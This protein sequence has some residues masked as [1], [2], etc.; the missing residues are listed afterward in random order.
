MAKKTSNYNYKRKIKNRFEREK[1][2]KYHHNSAS[3]RK[4]PSK[5]TQTDLAR[6]LQ[7]FLFFLFSWKRNEDI[8]TNNSNGS[9]SLRER[10]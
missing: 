8:K 2:T 1:K 4:A 5:K 6:S 7:F 10:R 9:D 3:T